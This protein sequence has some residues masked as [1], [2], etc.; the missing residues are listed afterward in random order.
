[1][2]RFLACFLLLTF[3]KAHAQSKQDSINQIQQWAKWYDLDFTPAESDSM[4][5]GLQDL[6]TTYKA[7][8]KTLPANDLAFP[9]AFEPAPYGTVIS[10]NQQKIL[11]DIPA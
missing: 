3:S 2:K 4:L 7:L 9:F 1:M 5:G 8:H 10:N 6:T 11:W